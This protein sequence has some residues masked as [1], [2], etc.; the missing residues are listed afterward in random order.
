V[1]SRYH[2]GQ[3]ADVT[4][5]TNAAENLGRFV[6]LILRGAERVTPGA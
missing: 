6:G 3:F 2:D 1:R 4:G 5:L